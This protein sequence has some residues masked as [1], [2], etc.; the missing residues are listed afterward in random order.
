MNLI[1]YARMRRNIPCLTLEEL[2]GLRHDI[3]VHLKEVGQIQTKPFSPA[4]M[5]FLLEEERERLTGFAYF[6]LDYQGIHDEIFAEIMKELTSFTATVFTL[7]LPFAG[8]EYRLLQITQRYDLAVLCPQKENVAKFILCNIEKFSR[9][10]LKQI[11]RKIDEASVLE[12]LEKESVQ[13]LYKICRSK[14]SWWHKFF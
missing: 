11:Y 1:E 10:E 6:L 9:D 8:A 12:F 14:T 2:G 13:I 5:L 4:N 3:H 7:N